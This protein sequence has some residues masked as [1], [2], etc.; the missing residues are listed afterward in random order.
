MNEERLKEIK[1]SIDFQML[2]AKINGFNPE[3]LEEEL[4][5]YN[6]VIRLRQGYIDYLERHI[7]DIYNIFKGK[8]QPYGEERH[9]LE[10]SLNRYKDML[11][12]V[13]GER[14]D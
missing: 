9:L 7:K 1:D 11:N 13:K 4:D 12:Y 14:Y 5:L 6:E 3:L 10:C 8:I 2:A